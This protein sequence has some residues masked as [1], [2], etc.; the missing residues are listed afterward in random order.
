[1]K[2]TFLIILLSHPFISISFS[3]D[4]LSVAPWYSNTKE[5]GSFYD[6]KLTEVVYD[7]DGNESFRIKPLASDLK[8]N[9]L[10][11]FDKDGPLC[12]E[13]ILESWSTQVEDV[14]DAI[15]SL[16]MDDDI[17]DLVTRA[18]LNVYEDYEDLIRKQ[19]KLKMG[20]LQKDFP[21][22]DALKEKLKVTDGSQP[23]TT[24]EK[25]LVSF[26]FDPC[27]SKWVKSITPHVGKKRA[28]REQ[29]SA[30]LEKILK[31]MQTHNA[32]IWVTQELFDL[33]SNRKNQLG[34]EALT[35]EM[36]RRVAT[37]VFFENG[38]KANGKPVRNRVTGRVPDEHSEYLVKESEDHPGWS[39]R[40][41][42]YE[43]A[44][45]DTP[46]VI[47]RQ[48]LRWTKFQDRQDPDIE[49][50]R[51]LR[52]K[53]TGEVVLEEPHQD[54][55]KYKN[56][57]LNIVTDI[58]KDEVLA[59]I[60]V[61]FLDAV[62]AGIECGNLNDSNASSFLGKGFELGEGL[63]EMWAQSN[64]EKGVGK[65]W[66]LKV[67]SAVAAVLP[68]PFNIFGTFILTTVQILQKQKTPYSSPRSRG[69][70]HD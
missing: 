12:E 56:E 3:E 7:T 16:R 67:G 8:K 2:F 68:P 60:P 62:A 40:Q 57:L 22:P 13:R 53:S 52:R 25:Q 47:A 39:E 49:E 6:K 36:I 70:A 59:D 11:E 26:S 37:G 1:M 17:D 55:T 32:P 30:S 46:A 10:K 38:K 20:S 14:R 33:K 5:Y 51:I 61:D 41:W 21:L 43:L 15:F 42:L 18:L 27:L 69:I 48:S 63:S 54:T 65:K 19:K 24:E 34:A 44:S 45:R 31:V 28:Q 35:L 64:D 58:N 4:T 9:L 66:A 50:V 29:T 23:L